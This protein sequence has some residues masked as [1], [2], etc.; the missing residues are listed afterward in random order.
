MGKETDGISAKYYR[1]LRALRRET[2]KYEGF[3]GEPRYR[4]CLT[5]RQ[6]PTESRFFAPDT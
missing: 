3:E 1:I 2:G 6:E 5:R 4:T